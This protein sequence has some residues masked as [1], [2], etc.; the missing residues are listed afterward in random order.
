[1]AYQDE[2]PRAGVFCRLPPELKE[3]LIRA[4]R[5]AERSL[6]AEATFRLRQSLKQTA[7]EAAA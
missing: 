4:A 1:M 5:A 6:A 3:R 2:A 7:D